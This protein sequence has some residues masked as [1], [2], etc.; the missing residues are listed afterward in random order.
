MNNLGEIGE[1]AKDYNGTA[2][3]NNQIKITMFH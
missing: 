1:E 3:M 2:S